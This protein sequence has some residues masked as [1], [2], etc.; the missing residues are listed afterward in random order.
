ME[1]NPYLVKFKQQYEKSSRKLKDYRYKRPEWNITDID[2]SSHTPKPKSDF[3]S[4]GEQEMLR[5]DYI[6]NSATRQEKQLMARIKRD[7]KSTF[8]SNA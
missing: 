5:N 2:H 8:K 7:I 1:Q 3:L 6:R 4:F